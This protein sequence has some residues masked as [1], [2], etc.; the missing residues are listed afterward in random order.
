MTPET[1]LTIG[2][3]A[4][5]TLMTTASPI[6][7]VIL[8]TG[9][10]ISILQALTQINEATLSFVPKLVLSSLVLVL[11]GPW[12]LSNLTDFISRMILSIPAVINGQPGF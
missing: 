5:E 2:R 12:M 8:V 11:A 10:L 6:L 1:V 7:L 4:L 9:L 3:Q